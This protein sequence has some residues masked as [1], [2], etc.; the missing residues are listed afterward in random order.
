[1][2]SKTTEDLD[3]SNE[4]LIGPQRMSDDTFGYA[5]LQLGGDDSNTGHPPYAVVV[6]NSPTK[7][8]RKNRQILFVFL[9]IAL[10]LLCV[11]FISLYASKKSEIESLRKAS[12][13]ER[14]CVSPGCVAAANFMEAAID[15]SANPCDNFYQY[16]C[17]GW[18]EKNPIPEEQSRL[19]VDSVLANRNMYVLRHILEGH[20]KGKTQIKD[21]KDAEQKAR[22]F[23]KACMQTDAIKKAGKQPLID[24]LKSFHDAVDASLNRNTAK[25]LTE[26][27]VV[28]NRNYSIS[29]LFATY[30]EVDARNSSQNAIQV[31]NIHTMWL[32]FL[33]KNEQCRDL[34]SH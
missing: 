4:D 11:V 12:Q 21:S 34:I 16:A 13:K 10:A 22:N 8:R 25:L 24:L 17:G 26:K 6:N 15:R 2:Y 19:G 3:G 28:L 5:Q 27:M 29:A 30:V 9:F 20:G 7:S 23:Y 14:V 31:T 32:T 18:I 1:M 33:C